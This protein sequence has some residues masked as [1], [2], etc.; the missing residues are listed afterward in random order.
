MASLLFQPLAASNRSALV[1]D[2]LKKPLRLTYAGFLP[3]AGDLA[4]DTNCT[5]VAKFGEPGDYTHEIHATC[6]DRNFSTKPPR[7]RREESV[8]GVYAADVPSEHIREKPYTVAS[9]S[10]LRLSVIER[11]MVQVYK[12][13]FID[14]ISCQLSL[15]I[16]T[17]FFVLT[18]R[19]HMAARG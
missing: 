12:H 7:I 8:L 19:P 1:D 9:M 14:R 17:G 11:R 10:R 3:W 18:R 15:A 13:D 5:G 6:A 2:I 4:R 16:K